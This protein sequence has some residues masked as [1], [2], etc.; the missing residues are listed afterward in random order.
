MYIHKNRTLAQKSTAA[1]DKLHVAM[2]H[3]FVR[4]HYKPMGLSG[5]SLREAL[6]ELQPEIYG[7]I[8]NPKKVDLKGLV[9][10]LDRLPYGIEW[11]Q[12]VNL[13]S[14]EGLA[15][16]NFT[17]IIAN[18]RR[19][20]CYK[21]SEDQIN[22]EITRGR[23]D[24][25]DILTHL[26]FLYIESHKIIDRMFVSDGK[27]YSHEW[28]AIKEFVE[29]PKSFPKEKIKVLI[30]YL[31]NILGSTFEEVLDTYN[32][33]STQ[34][35]EHR[36]FNVILGLGTLAA[37]EINNNKH[38]LVRFSD[39][40]INQIGHH[41]YGTIW[42]NNVKKVLYSK[43]LLKRPIHIISANMHSVLNSIYA[44]L[45]LKINH[46]NRFKHY[47]ELSKSSDKS[48]ALRKKVKDFAIQNGLTEIK[49]TSGTN[50]DV[51]IID[52]KALE[53]YNP[54]L[55]S[56]KPSTCE[57]PVLVI[58]DYAFGEQAFETMDELLKPYKNGL[59][60]KIFL[61]IQSISIMG[62]AGILVGGKGDIMLPTAHVFEGSSGNY[63][64]NNELN[65]D[66]FNEDDLSVYQGAMVTVMGTSLQNKYILEYFKTSTWNVVGIEM[67]GGHYQKAIQAASR[68]RNHISK[69]VKVRYAY[70]ASDN[71]L[72][73][74]ST[75]ASGGLGLSG[76]KP[77]YKITEKIIKQIFKSE[78]VC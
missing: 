33:L 35:D 7:A 21:V 3:L 22:I 42:A 66:D 19:R 37:Q 76:V 1:I 54:H 18:K 64:F 2:R 40:L 69:D 12:F 55:L 10:V 48:L 30:V 38:R 70:Y 31:S 46:N 43:N 20:N 39:L 61:N 73:T 11:S 4:G 78:V 28:I 26:T 74:G 36:L 5:M 44:E 57:L 62:K 24:V 49:D 72:D 60:E 77:T 29:N 53:S 14:V 67:E 63:V 25:Y 13:T 75:L 58:M 71:P 45:A 15:E 16:G 23:S 27:E 41:V 32:T 17:K 65:N 6:L 52:T 8:N 47:E 51:Q 59:N 34:K 9:Y 68:V 50:I 56:A